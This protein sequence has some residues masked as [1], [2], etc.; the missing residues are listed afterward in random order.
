MQK[1]TDTLN[2][3]KIKAD[4]ELDHLVQAITLDEEFWPV[5]NGK[6]TR[7]VPFFPLKQVRWPV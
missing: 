7:R 1:E 5:K 4:E 3:K 6:G 2:D